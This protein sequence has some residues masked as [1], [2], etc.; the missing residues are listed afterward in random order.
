[1]ASQNL[2]A[3]RGDLPLNNNPFVV[4]H[5]VLILAVPWLLTLGMAGLAVGDPVF[6]A[7]LEIFLLGFPAIAWVTWIQWQQPFS[8]F[9]L[10]LVAKPSA[11]LSDRDR[12]I[13][14]LI[15]Q[16]RN[17]W[18]VTGWI[19]IAVAIFMS[20]MFRQIYLSA[21]LAQAIAPFPAGLRFFGILWAEFFFL[22]SNVLLQSGISAL[23]INI[24]AESELTSLQ[25]YPI[26]RI[27]N[28]FTEIGWRSPQL[29]KFFEDDQSFPN[30]LINSESTKST[31]SEVAEKEGNISTP[32]VSDPLPE[33]ITGEFSEQIE[34]DNQSPDPEKLEPN[35]LI[36]EITDTS[37]NEDRVAQAEELEIS[38]LIAEESVVESVIESVI[39]L[40]F[41]ISDPDLENETL[42]ESE[43]LEVFNLVEEDKSE[44]E[45]IAETIN[46][47]LEI[48]DL[49]KPEIP[50][51]IFD[52]VDDELD[53]LIAFNIYVEN[54]IQ[55]YLK[56]PF[57]EVEDINEVAA[58][59]SPVTAIAEEIL[60]SEETQA[61][62]ILESIDQSP[63]FAQ[64][65]EAI[66]EANIPMDVE[67]I[68]DNILAVKTEVFEEIPEE[69]SIDSLEEKR[70]TNHLVKELLGNKFLARLEELNIADKA[71]RQPVDQSINTPSSEVDEFADL[72]A[73]INGKPLPKQEN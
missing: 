70:T 53:E 18:H 65:P 1:M 61:E 26:D 59:S 4:G 40:D 48:N 69:I 19:A 47:D 25:P 36:A 66:A 43:E 11:T 58:I 38:E 30:T 3:L 22:L 60:V 49:I 35:T 39:E 13:L 10:W 55:D 7:W 37:L 28:S 31:K 20:I 50:A 64:E 72:E 34:E 41:K 57:T 5:I 14:T 56:E 15:R 51:N 71:N 17:G 67:T 27:K 21:P 68:A 23:R 24:T 2:S 52:D 8:P 45:A 73:L 16:H 63:I 33:T 44:L 32:I 42:G 6:P 29:L 62:K 46:L 9:S 54:I 12:R